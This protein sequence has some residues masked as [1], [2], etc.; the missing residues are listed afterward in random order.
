MY[1]ILYTKTGYFIVKKTCVRVDLM[2]VTQKYFYFGFQMPKIRP[3]IKQI[4]PVSRNNFN[5]YI[6]LSHILNIY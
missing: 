4:I 3:G 2:L 5:D 1:Y 6:F